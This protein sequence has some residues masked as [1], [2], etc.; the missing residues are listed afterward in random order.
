MEVAGAPDILVVNDGALGRD[1]GAIEV[2][3]QDR[4]D[5]GVGARADVDAPVAGCFNPVAVVALDQVDDADRGAEP[6]LGVRLGGHDGCDHSC[7]GRADGGGVPLEALHVPVSETLVVGGHVVRDRGRASSARRPNM[8]GNPF[9][10]V[11]Y[12]DRAGGKAS[13]DLLAEQGVGDAVEVLL[14]FHVVVDADPAA[15]PFRIDVGASCIIHDKNDFRA[16]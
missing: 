7:S 1:V 5:G 2:A 16:M 15:L 10:P 9:V 3:L 11:K 8:G 6:L 14:D 4:D 12:L 13:V